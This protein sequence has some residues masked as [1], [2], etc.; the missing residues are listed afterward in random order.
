[1]EIDMVKI[2]FPYRPWMQGYSGGITTFNLNLRKRW[3]QWLASRHG[4][5]ISWEKSPWHHSNWKMN[6]SQSPF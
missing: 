4:R 1:M 2:N 3:V 5:F 6:G